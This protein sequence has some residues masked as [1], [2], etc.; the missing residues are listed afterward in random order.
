VETRYTEVFARDDREIARA[1]R[2]VTST[3]RSW[4]ID[5]EVPVLV[6]LTSELVTNALV[7]GT[8]PVQVRLATDARRI[9]LEVIDDDGTPATPHLVERQGPGGWGLQLVDRLAHRWGVD[10]SGD[11][12]LVWVE[13]LRP[14]PTGSAPGG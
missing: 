7:H 2:V 3:L 1:R 4:G 11:T 13:T 6:L 10:E 12:T 14:S 8:G 5:A 9:R